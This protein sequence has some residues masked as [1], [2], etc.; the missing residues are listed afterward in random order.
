M[1]WQTRA[2]ATPRALADR[3]HA[4]WL[5][6]NPLEAT[7]YGVPGYDDRVPDASDAGIAAW[8][9]QVES[10]LDEARD[11]DASALGPDDAVTL[12][13]LIEHAE[14]E[15]A[16]ID[17]A[18]E[19]YT[20]TAMPFAGPPVYLAVL[21]R[22]VL[23]DA[24]AAQDYVS[25]VRAG[26]TY[27][28]Q[29][30]ARVQA[31]AEK[32]RLPV[33]PLVE[34]AIAWGEGLL[35]SPVPAAICAPQPPSAWDGHAAWESERDEAA[36]EQVVPAIRRWVDALKDLLPRSRPETQ[37]GLCFLEGGAEL[38][39]QAI[40]LHTTLPLSA[41]TLH[42]TGLAHVE[43]LE[44]RALELGGAVGLADLSSIRAAVRDS[45]GRVPPAEAMAAARS[46]VARAEARASEVFPAPLPGPCAVQPMPSVVA[47]SGA[48]PHY[49][50]P[51]LDGTRPG[52]YWFNTERPTAG[53]GWDLESVAFHEAVPGHHLQLSRVQLLTDLPDLQRIRHLTV[54]GEGWGLY[55]EQL[56]EEMGLYAG[57][58]GLLGSVTASLMRAG[59]LVVDTGIHAFGWTRQQAQ[60]WFVE[61]VPMPE[62][63]LAREIDRY[64]TMPGQAL[65]YLTGKLQ[66]LEVREAA[67]RRLGSSFSLPGFHAAVLDHG[68]LP[69]PVLHRVVEAWDGGLR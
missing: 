25:R 59:R 61:H 43:A 49:T 16:G 7:T 36:R 8:R 47:E 62:V 38:Y 1:D 29:L 23:P 52:T 65:S 3:V 56:A 15:R 13:V 67:Q 14:Q 58:E 46:A 24:R 26:G 39:A 69:M 63:F 48:A 51:R 31:G 37:A 10:V 5:A 41:E 22:T 32:G 60:Q 21:A 19:E 27:V 6:A 35:S 57:P 45:A 66:L 64:I 28:D 9:R 68:S 4:E 18:A 42:K 34:Q 33:A 12:G 40:R 44:A 50:P 11:V 54:F 2:M 17:M 53:T 30:T 20:V 55:A